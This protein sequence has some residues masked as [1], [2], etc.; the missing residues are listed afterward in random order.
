MTDKCYS[1][2]ITETLACAAHVA[3]RC[4]DHA[5][6]I[7]RDGAFPE[8]EFRWLHEAGLLAAPLRPELGGVGIGVLPGTTPALLTL[9]RHI[10]R[11][12]LAVGRLFEGHVNALLLLQAFG[13]EKQQASWAADVHAGRQFSVWNTQAEDGV[14]I[15]ALPNGRFELQGAKTFASGAEHVARPLITGAMEDGSGWQ[16]VIVPT[17]RIQTAVSDSS[18]WHPLGMRAT[19]SVHMDF[20]GLEVS[21]EDLLG[22]PGDY[23]K[24]PAF[25]GGGIR[26]MAVQMGGAAAVL[27]YTREFLRDQDRTGDPFQR[28]RVGKMASLIETGDLW[29]RGAGEIADN[30]EADAD[31]VVQYAHMARAVIE[32]ICLDI[33]RLSERCVGA[34]GLLRPNPFER[35][36]RDLTL[37]LR[38]PGSDAALVDAGHYV[39]ES[40]DSS[41]ALWHR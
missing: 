9:L 26:F 37:Y 39:L 36:H 38:Q 31:T 28:E 24:Q 11:G 20:T 25:G 3:D 18:F 15:H 29:L 12:N 16:M 14:H 35:I 17:E 33:L 40:Q 10:G 1:Q 23:Y 30:P 32:N 13:A 4:A 6:A 5:A 22:Q 19:A 41:H 27:D 21:P 34:R 8:E 7:D 2:A